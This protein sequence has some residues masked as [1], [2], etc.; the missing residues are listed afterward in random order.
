VQCR[1]IQSKLES[2]QARL[3]QCQGIN[4]Q[5]L[6]EM[7]YDI[8]EAGQM[9]NQGVMEVVKDWAELKVDVDQLKS[10]ISNWDHAAVAQ[11]LNRLE[12]ERDGL[13][14]KVSEL[15][16]QLRD[17]RGE[18][19]SEVQT[20]HRVNLDLR[21]RNA[22]YKD[23]V[24]NMQDEAKKLLTEFKNVSSITDKGRFDNAVS[25]LFQVSCHCPHWLLSIFQFN[26]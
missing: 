20:L 14:D 25:G 13:R 21:S 24:D 22:A 6:G 7:S 9:V 15:Q 10:T 18:F 17:L 4:S 5:V 16:D 1:E 8:Q 26:C 19:E 3:Q 23:R 12:K 2:V 11:E